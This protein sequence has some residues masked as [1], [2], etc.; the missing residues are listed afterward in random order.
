MRPTEEELLNGGDEKEDE[1]LNGGDE[2]ED[3][4]DVEMD[5]PHHSRAQRASSRR[6]ISAITSAVKG[7]HSSFLALSQVST[8][9]QWV[10]TVFLVAILLV[11]CSL[12]Y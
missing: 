2:K 1:L 7:T 9:K 3:P 4:T 11:T 12:H 5:R 8:S 6:S 10:V